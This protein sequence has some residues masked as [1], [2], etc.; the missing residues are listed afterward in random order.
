MEKKSKIQIA[1]LLL[2]L[3]GIGFL[4]YNKSCPLPARPDKPAAAHFPRTINVSAQGE[5]KTKP[6]LAILNLGVESIQPRLSAAIGE[7]NTKMNE[8]FEKLKALGIEEKDMQSEVSST[9]QQNFENGQAKISGYQVNN[10]ITLQIHRLD[11]VTTILDTAQDLGIN[12]ISNLTWTLDDNSEA[13]SQARTLAIQNALKNA[14]EIAKASGQKLG[15]LLSVSEG[16]SPPF[17]GIQQ[18]RGL[19]LTKADNFAPTIS[20]GSLEVSVQVDAVFEIE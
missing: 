17:F 7:A 5:I 12:K 2:I 4:C 8:L 20:S 3:I 14:Q 9:P 1:L 10:S 19:S 11:Q 18:S 6:N 15:K 13:R 16:S